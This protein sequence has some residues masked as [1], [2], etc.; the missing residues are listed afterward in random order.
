MTG[1]MNRRDVTREAFP[2]HF[3]AAALVQGATV[4]P[5]DTYQGPFI[6]VPNLGRFWLVGDF[7]GRW[8]SERTD[9]MSVAFHLDDGEIHAAEIFKR[10]VD[11]V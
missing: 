3:A 5:F 10:F 8:W 9:R 4:E 2:Y 6:L 11:H 7:V 1:E